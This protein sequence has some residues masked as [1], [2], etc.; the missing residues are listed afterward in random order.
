[1]G[2]FVDVITSTRY[3]AG[4]DWAEFAPLFAAFGV[5]SSS[6][7]REHPEKS[8]FDGVILYGTNTDFEF[9]FLRDG[10]S[11]AKSVTTVPLDG[12]SEVA[13]RPDLAIVDESD[14]LFLDAASTSAILGYTSETHFEWVYRPVYDA[15]CRGV[16]SVSGVRACLAA[17]DAGRAATLADAMLS[18]WVALAQ[19]ARDGLV[20]G[21]DY[22]VTNAGVEIVDAQI[23]GRVAHASRWSG[24]LHEF[25]EVKEGVPVQNQNTTIASVCH[26]TF[27]DRY[28]FLF[29]LT[30]TVGEAAERSEIRTVYRVDAFDVPPNRACRRVRDATRIFA[31]AGERDDAILASVRAHRAAERPTLVLFATINESLAFARA[32]TLAGIRCL[33]LNDAQKEDEDYILRRAGKPGAVTVATNAAGRGTDVELSPAALQA[34]GLHAIIGFLPVNLRVEVQALGRAA[35]QGQCGSCEIL[36]AADEDFARKI[37]VTAGEDV[38]AVYGRRTQQI[39][40]ESLIRQTRTRRERL[41]FAA[42]TRFFDVINDLTRQMRCAERETGHGL[43]L[44]GTVQTVKQEW[45][46]FF[47]DMQHWAINPTEETGNEWSA[48][49]VS[50]FLAGSSAAKLIECDWYTK[51]T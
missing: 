18:V 44:I 31:T 7:A 11:H 27:F 38:S 48:R 3:L 15:V 40:I 24:G 34:G 42:L 32:L 6:I 45:A 25:V 14:N 49:I 41:V 51:P 4:R 8:A 5:S 37:N 13:R 50:Q 22:I 9:A 12:F 20:R 19:R 47:T 21:R 2:F 17:V 10:I 30:G 36:F 33:V 23:T 29:G 35:R 43:Q 39:M 28:G 26:P 46:T 16:L 1:M